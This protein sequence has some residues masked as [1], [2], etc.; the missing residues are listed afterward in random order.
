MLLVFSRDLAQVLTLNDYG[1]Q[2]FPGGNCTQN[3]LTPVSNY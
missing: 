1:S 2:T 3:E